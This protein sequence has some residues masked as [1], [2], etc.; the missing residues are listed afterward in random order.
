MVNVQDKVFGR[1]GNRFFQLAYI[2]AQFRQGYLPDMYLQ[3]PKYFDRYKDE[4]KELFKQEGEPLDYISIHVRRGKNPSNPDEPAYSE[5][6]FYTDLSGTD[7]YLNAQAEFPGEKFMIFS[8][9]PEW[10]ID[11]FPRIRGNEYSFE[12]NDELIDFNW[13]ARCKGH[14][15]ANS[16]FSWWAA[17]L[18]GGKTIAPKAWYSDGIERTKVPQDWIQV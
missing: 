9:D 15:I 11:N 18:G 14:I 5:N 3:D 16:S 6:P 8:D 17:Y 13:M 1:M 10:C 12:M 2:Y 4:L 7:Y